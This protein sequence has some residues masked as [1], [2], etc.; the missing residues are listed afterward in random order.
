[1]QCTK[2]G[3]SKVLTEGLDNG[4]IKVTCQECGHSTIK[5]Q[6]GRQMLTDDAPVPDR[7]EYLTEG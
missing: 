1:M 6:Q 3:S 2:C 5:D 7:R 4:K